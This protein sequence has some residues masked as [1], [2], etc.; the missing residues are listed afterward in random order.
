MEFGMNN[1]NMVILWL[2]LLNKLSE[3][4]PNLSVFNSMASDFFYPNMGGVEEHI[5]NLS[6]CLVSRGHKVSSMI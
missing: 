5:F 1:E 4:E 2:L 6:E 3:H